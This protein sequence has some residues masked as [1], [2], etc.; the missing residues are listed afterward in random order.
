MQKKNH[1]DAVITVVGHDQIGLIAKVSTLLAEAR[2]N[3][4]DISQT[5]MDDVFTM[6]MLVDLEN[7]DAELKDISARLENLGH[8]LG[9]SIRVQHADIF[10][11]MHRI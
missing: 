10:D 9:V 4:K 5:I 2:I 11:A 3:I 1:N 7:M 8:D 6:V